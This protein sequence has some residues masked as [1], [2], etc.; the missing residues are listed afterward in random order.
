MGFRINTNVAAMNAHMNSLNNNRALDKSLSALSSGLRINKAADDA[1]GMAI[2]NQLRSQSTGLGQAIRNANDGINL[3]QTAD[4]AL[5]EY[6][7]ILNTI[8]TKAVQAA[9]DSQTA[10][11][12]KAI[13]AD[14]D[15]LL[16]EAQNIAKSTS[17]N[18]QKLLSGAFTG[19]KFQIGANSNQTVS[20]NI[21]D[22]RTNKV[23][24]TTRSE[25]SVGEG[26]IG[27]QLKNNHN[28]ETISLKKIDIQYNNDAENGLGA[29]ADEIN[30][31]TA[32][33]GIKANAIVEVSTTSAI[34]AGT[35]GD[36]FSINGVNIGAI[37]VEDNDSN[38]A[39]VN[40]INDKKNQTGVT[41]SLEGGKLTL[42]SNDGRAIK[43][44]GNI[45]S[46]FGNSSTEMSTLGKIELVQNGTGE[47]QIEGVGAGATGADIKINKVTT[48]KD[49]ILAADSIIASGSEIAAG[50][51]IGG[52]AS[53]LQ[54]IES[55]QLDTKLK[56]GS[57]I[58]HGSTISAGTTITGQMIVGGAKDS[59]TGS[60]SSTTTTA[61]TQ[62]MKLTK[63][64]KLTAGSV[65]GKDTVITTE[66]TEGGKTYK[67][68]D[69][70]SSS[71][72]LT[73]DLSLQADMTLKYS[74]TSGDNSKIEM[75]SRINS[76]STL[77][78]DLLVGT[79]YDTTSG[80][81]ATQVDI[82]TKL[83]D[84]TSSSGNATTKSYVLTGDQTYTVD[85]TDTDT[86]TLAEGS[87]LTSGTKFTVET[88]VAWTG[89]DLVTDQGVIHNGENLIAGTTY[90]LTDSATVGADIDIEL[91]TSTDLVL[92]NGSILSDGF[93]IAQGA[94][95]TGSWAATTDEGYETVFQ[96]GDAITTDKVLGADLTQILG[97][98][99]DTSS[100]TVNNSM[101]IKKGSLLKE[102]TILSLD[103]STSYSGPTLITDKGV[104]STGDSI[105]GGTYTLSEDQILSAD[106]TT[107][108]SLGAN[109]SN[110]K[111]VI[112]SGS[113]L[114]TGSVV[115]G[116]ATLGTV[117]TSETYELD[118]TVTKDMT[119]NS[120]MILKSGSTLGAGSTM[121]AGSTL[122]SDTYVYGDGA[123]DGV[124]VYSKS[125]IKAGSTLEDQTI[126]GE[127]S[128]IGGASTVNSDTT[129]TSDMT[130]KTGTKLTSTAGH[131]TMF[132]AGTV[133][134]QD[135][136][137]TDA[138]AGTGGNDIKIKAGQTLSQ[139]L[140]I[141]QGDTITLSKDMLMKKD[142]VIAQ[143]S[144]LAVNT[145]NAG[146]V[147]VGSNEISSLADID[148]TTL[149]GAMK[150]IDTLDA[151]LK[152]IDSIR[153]DIGSTQNQ[154]ESTI[155]NISVTKVNL[156]AAESTIRDVDF[157]E[158]SANLQ[159]RNILAQSGVYA[160]SQANA[161]QQ[162]V[163][164]LLQ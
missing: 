5:E 21:A 114:L 88:D 79:T 90:T 164:R 81:S 64:S 50:S 38:G 150:A 68:G 37:T 53:V 72:T 59:N 33:T 98:N 133:I 70:L 105:S 78:A 20:L 157:A 26:E 58:K 139:D 140:Y 151:A 91:S 63:G 2:A 122:G 12:R 116:T 115:N 132:K 8:R 141:K 158:E 107:M 24:V 16:E 101:T 69:V 28:G 134:N 106:L 89:S 125:N 77:G 99:T 120:D 57:V 73:S 62:D 66:F 159:K 31:Y 129:L 108:T 148:V 94:T 3:V 110:A 6:T 61:L 93:K 143:D 118:K 44:E 14:I 124:E 161:A 146:T 123:N 51:Q 162:N 136:T 65:L 112:K 155:R 119:V 30:K 71:L 29:L 46:V 75:G 149:E 96:D 83:S 84:A 127:G 76:G 144:V 130:L 52:D 131:V 111:N 135:M 1:S 121:S 128:T 137:L 40:A 160:M 82:D 55:T 145:D 34:K 42:T 97:T 109:V 85:G 27:L 67:V 156:T 126:L 17:F 87:L 56:A 60:S 54:K 104:L 36:D 32:E 41:A 47:F 138:S 23:G 48:S 18:G 152:Q 7:N 80:T 92:A 117:G 49:S 13:Q 153:S 102:G 154:L 163:M 113:I 35:T 4:G 10:D 45:S 19:K 11:S 100:A 22:T 25:L 147:D 39:L 74:S 86:V 103:E 9:S 142:S 15:K 95:E 43:V